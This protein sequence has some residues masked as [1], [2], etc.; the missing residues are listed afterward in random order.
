MLLDLT[1]ALTIFQPVALNSICSSCT[2]AEQVE[3]ITGTL[4][5]AEDERP[6]P[7]SSWNLSPVIGAQPCASNATGCFTDGASLAPADPVLGES[8]SDPAYGR[9]GQSWLN[10]AGQFI[11]P[12]VDALAPALSF[13]HLPY[14]LQFGL[15]WIAV[16]VGSCVASLLVLA[17]HWDNLG[18]DPYV[19]EIQAKKVQAI[20]NITL[21]MAEFDSQV[22][23]ILTQIEEDQERLCTKM[24][25]TMLSDMDACF[26]ALNTRMQ[27]ELDRRVAH[28]VGTV[29][30]TTV[31]PAPQSDAQLTSIDTTFA[32]IQ[33]KIDESQ[34]AASHQSSHNSASKRP[35]SSAQSTQGDSAQEDPSEADMEQLSLQRWQAAAG[36]N[37]MPEE[38]EKGRRIR[39][40][41]IDQARRRLF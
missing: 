30:S 36:Y 13:S 5:V 22:A 18:H 15:L 34:A 38:F 39:R 14:L 32:T 6:I 35:S 10:Q 27:T 40:R 24:R 33:A 16:L 20:R 12:V 11:Q 26:A 4:A 28:M 1:T 17:S 19:E 21:A 37:P 9:R 41:R 29:P 25:D 3:L 2:F 23:N 31:E 8:I 7:L